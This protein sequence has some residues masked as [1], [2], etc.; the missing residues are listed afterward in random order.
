MLLAN[1]GGSDIGDLDDS[2]LVDVGDLLLL[3]AAWGDC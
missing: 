1:W 3:L 2:G